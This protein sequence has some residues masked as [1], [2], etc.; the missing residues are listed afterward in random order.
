MFNNSQ[1]KICSDVGKC[2]N[3]L[4]ALGRSPKGLYFKK[5]L[6]HLK[7]SCKDVYNFFHDCKALFTFSRCQS[8][9]FIAQIEDITLTMMQYNILCAVKRFESYE[10]IGEPFIEANGNSL[11]LSAADKKCELILDAI[12]EIAELLYALIDGNDKFHVLYRMYKYN[13]T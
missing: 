5:L 2:L 7:K 1:H 13:V 10:N 9:H 3:S 4:S 12:L 6:I 11:E 8:V